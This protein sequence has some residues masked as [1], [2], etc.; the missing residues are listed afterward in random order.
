LRTLVTTPSL[1]REA[2]TVT[3]TIQRAVSGL[4]PWTTARMLTGFTGPQV[5]R[6]PSRP[7][8]VIA[9]HP[10]GLRLQ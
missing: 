7:S 9:E 6:D 4:D 2:S 1:R 10:I 3:V 8:E 5:D